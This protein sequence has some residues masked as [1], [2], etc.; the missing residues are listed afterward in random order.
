MTDLHAAAKSAW[1]AGNHALAYQCLVAALNQSPEDW[2]TW[3]DWGAFC[4]ARRQYHAAAAALARARTLG[5]N[6]HAE[7][8]NGL[9]WNLHLSGRTAEA[10][11]PLRRAIELDPLMVKAH[12]NLS[13]I[14]GTLGRDDEAL[15]H[16]RTAVEVAPDDY[17]AHLALAFA[18]FF[19]GEWRAGFREFECRLPFKIPGMAS[20]PWPRWR[21]ENV[22]TLFILR[23]QGLGD[24]IQMLRYLW[25]AAERCDRIIV[26]VQRELWR[27]FQQNVP[28]NVE[29]QAMPC[30]LPAEGID[31]WTP[32]MTLAELFWGA[33]NEG[34]SPRKFFTNRKYITLWPRPTPDWPPRCIGLAWAGDPTHD[35]DLH[36]SIPL[37]E[38]IPLT[39]CPGLEFVSLQVG[40]RGTA[41]M[42][43]VGAHGLIRDASPEIFDMADTAKVIASLDLVITVDTAVGHLA[44]AMGVPCWLLVNQMGLD[45]RHGRAG[46]TT[47]WYPSMRIFRRALGESWKDVIAR[48]KEELQ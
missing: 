28:G 19:C 27:L 45:W 18:L 14:V 35:N 31:A 6:D 16:A 40:P 9:G 32:M 24:S 29:V 41:E 36:R 23:E 12:G 7:T 4:E 46:E 11:E 47:L 30:P 33:E 3:H 25:P 26:Q 13:Y 15:T 1:A 48:V 42:D 44:G 10:E 2:A 5:G 22:G 43:A 39:E 17:A 20:Y 34:G 8:L 38:L 37:T 21:G